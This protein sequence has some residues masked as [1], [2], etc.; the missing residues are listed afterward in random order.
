[1]AAVA[2]LQPVNA[3]EGRLAAQ[4]V[5]ADAWAMDCLRLAGERSCEFEAARKF[6]AQAM[7]LMREGKSVLRVLLRM[8]AARRVV[9]RDE[10]ASGRAAW[11]E[12]AAARM[13]A[14]ALGGGAE[15]PV[16]AGGGH[17]VGPSALPALVPQGVDGRHKAGQDEGVL[18]GEA[19]ERP[20]PMTDG[21]AAVSCNAINLRDTQRETMT[22]FPSPLVRA[23]A[24]NEAGGTRWA[25]AGGSRAARR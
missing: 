8:R 22:G 19:S 12:H 13:M 11:E 16:D 7:S 10:A 25:T 4:Y 15:G 9:E 14:E 3:A 1:M 24:G 18:D 23:V 5:A 2:A 20:A 6:R 21:V 17:P